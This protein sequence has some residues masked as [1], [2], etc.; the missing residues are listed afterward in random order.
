MNFEDLAHMISTHSAPVD[1]TETEI[2]SG[3]TSSPNEF[4]YETC[5]ITITW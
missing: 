2:Q 5:G 4:D 1:T 3:V